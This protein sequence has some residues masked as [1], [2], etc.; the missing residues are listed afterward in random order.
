ILFRGRESVLHHW[1]EKGVDGWRLDVAPDVG[2][3]MAGAMRDSLARPYPQAVLIGEVM[4]FG[5]EWAQ[6]Y[7]GV[8]NYYFRDAVRAWLV[9]RSVVAALSQADRDPQGASRAAP[10]QPHHVEP[11]AGHGGAHL[12]APHRDAR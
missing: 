11:H 9:G 8:M 10:G 12:H 7:H 5:G 6:T 4:G 2:L 3:P 1:L